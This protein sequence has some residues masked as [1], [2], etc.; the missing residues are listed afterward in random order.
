MKKEIRQ[1]SEDGKLVQVT[2]ADERWYVMTDKDKDG[3]ITE[4][5][6]YPSVTWIC[7]HYPK[8]LGFYKWLANKGWDEAEAIKEAA[9]DRGH[10][11]HQLITKLLS[12]DDEGNQQV[13]NMDDL[14]KNADTGTEEPLKLDE[15]E[16]VMSF[17][18]WFHAT[19]PEVIANEMVVV[20]AKHNYAGTADFICKINGETWLIDFKTAQT[21]WPSYELQ[22]AAYKHALDM[23]IDRMAVLQ[24]GYRR[25][26]KRYKLTEVDDQFELFL[27]AQQI[28]KRE[29]KGTKLF[30]KNYPTQLKLNFN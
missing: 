3:N 17:V 12:P 19:K 16:A 13:V 23:P 18:D 7:D 4:V 2:I 28:W 22:L 21:I 9:G 20:S 5:F 6:E 11:V 15:Y 10:K 8:G 27:A 25:N 26:G 29:T 14:V 30:K 1:V 24:V